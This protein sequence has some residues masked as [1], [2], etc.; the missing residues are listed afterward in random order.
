MLSILSCHLPICRPRAV[1]KVLD[2]KFPVAGM[3]DDKI[4][5]SLSS[6][7]ASLDDLPC[8]K[9]EGKMVG[10]KGLPNGFEYGPDQP[11]K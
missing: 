11:T 5:E 3:P 10:E 4:L 7:V 1:C 9:V 8:D 6:A 2:G